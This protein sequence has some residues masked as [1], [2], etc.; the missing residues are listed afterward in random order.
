MATPKVKKK[1]LAAMIASAVVSAISLPGT[2]WAQSSDA[3]LHGKATAN[4]DVAAKNVA[5]GAVRQA[6]RA[7]LPQERAHRQKTDNSPRV[8]R[9]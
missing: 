6:G 9:R 4:A 3:N 7:R 2:V 8:S 1:L 5:T